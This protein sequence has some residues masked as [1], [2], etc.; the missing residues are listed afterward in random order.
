MATRN[1]KDKTMKPGRELDALVAEFV[2]GYQ[3]WS[4][5]RIAVLMRPAEAK[6]ECWSGSSWTKG[7]AK[8]AEKDVDGHTFKGGHNWN[9]PGR[10]IVAKYSTDIDAAWSVLTTEES[11]EWEIHGSNFLHVRGLS[12]RVGEDFRLCRNYPHQDEYWVEYMTPS[13]LKKGPIGE[14]MP[15]AICLAALEAVGYGKEKV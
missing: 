5:I 3:W 15:H 10:F 13:G 2:M 9:G 12:S 6:Q 1:K 8:G 7:I 14:T 11:D 4:F